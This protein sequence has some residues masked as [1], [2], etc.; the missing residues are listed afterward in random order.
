MLWG[1]GWWGGGA[2]CG[3]RAPAQRGETPT[4]PLPSDASSGGPARGVPWLLFA[5]GYPGTSAAAGP[6]LPPLRETIDVTAPGIKVETVQD[7]G[8][9]SSGYGP[10]LRFGQ[11]FMASR[12]FS[13]CVSRPATCQQVGQVQF[14]LHRTGGEAEA[15][16][17]SGS[18]RVTGSPGWRLATRSGLLAS[19][20]TSC[21]LLRPEPG[22]G[23]SASATAVCPPRL[24]MPESWHAGSLAGLGTWACPSCRVTLG[25]SLPL[26]FW[27][28]VF[29]SVKCG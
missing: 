29:S 3:A 8:T 13:H 24:L 11:H 28:S 14:C 9:F 17:V 6:R 20:S 25:K 2:G 7:V 18:P 5:R 23:C 27:A 4:A 21:L 10:L 22:P 12:V 1:P 26:R 16:E 19:T 15:P